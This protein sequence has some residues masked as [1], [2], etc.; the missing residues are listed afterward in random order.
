M[1]WKKSVDHLSHKRVFF[2]HSVDGKVI[3]KNDHKT[4]KGRLQEQ[5]QNWYRNLSEEANQNKENTEKIDIEICLK[6]INKN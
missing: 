2:S 6:K 3:A 1:T 5:T 4:I